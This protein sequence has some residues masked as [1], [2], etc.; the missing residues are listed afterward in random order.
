MSA[1]LRRGNEISHNQLL[2]GKK[3]SCILKGR[4]FSP[5]VQ[6][7][8]KSCSSCSAI[9]TG[10]ASTCEEDNTLYKRDDAS[11]PLSERIREISYNLRSLSTSTSLRIEMLDE[12]VAPGGSS[13][14][15]DSLVQVFLKFFNSANKEE[16]K[17]LKIC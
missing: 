11:P 14:E 12:V 2:S 3:G 6:N 13:Q 7:S 10:R 15:K 1:S 9:F 5:R 4:Y 8:S 17:S 16:L